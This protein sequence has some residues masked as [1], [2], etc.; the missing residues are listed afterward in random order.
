MTIEIY[1]IR[2]CG[3]MKKAFVW[4]ETRGVPYEFHDY[5]REGVA[6]DRLAA[7]VDRVGWERLINRQGTTFRG[8]PAADKTD[9]DRTRALKLMVD[10][11][12]LIRRPV[13]VAGDDLLIGFDEAKWAATLRG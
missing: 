4:F 3:T 6:T 9:L 11:P 8:L 10:K 1:G 2:N 12:S 7:W 5:K 13:V